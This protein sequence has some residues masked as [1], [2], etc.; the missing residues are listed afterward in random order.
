MQIGLKQSG[1]F[2]VN[3]RVDKVVPVHCSKMLLY[4]T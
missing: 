3:E 2:S 1:V 4:L